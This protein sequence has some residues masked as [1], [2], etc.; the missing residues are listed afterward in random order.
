MIIPVSPVW[1][2]ESLKIL[3]FLRSF[4]VIIREKSGVCVAKCNELDCLVQLLTF[5][6]VGHRHLISFSL[7][8]LLQIPTAYGRE[9]LDVLRRLEQLKELESENESDNREKATARQLNTI[10]GRKLD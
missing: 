7:I 4:V 9:R 3:L 6:T 2:I 1:S 8:L 5:P 10:S